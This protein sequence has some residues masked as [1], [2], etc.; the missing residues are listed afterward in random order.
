LT[1]L[2]DRFR[3]VE[4]TFDTPPPLPDRPPATW[5]Q[6]STSAAVIRF[7]ASGFDPEQTAVEIR[8]TFAEVKNTSFSPMSLRS[9]FLAM[10]KSRRDAT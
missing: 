8:N 7:I 9:I 10:A 1:S 6:L 4:L 3:E 2:V 5:M